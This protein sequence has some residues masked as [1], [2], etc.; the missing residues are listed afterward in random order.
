MVGATD[1]FTNVTNSITTNVLII[2]DY[3]TGKG[4]N[5]TQFA[6]GTIS[7]Y[8]GSGL[9]YNSSN[10]II[11]T[12]SGGS[13]AYYFNTTI[14]NVTGYNSMLLVPYNPKTARVSST[15][16]SGNT[17]IANYITPKTGL[18]FIPFGSYECHDHVAETTGNK[19]VQIYCIIT[20]VAANG[21][22][23]NTIGT[24]ELSPPLTSSETE[25]RIYY[26][27]ANTYTIN[28]S[29]R[30][31][32][33]IYASV[34][35]GGSSP[36]VTQWLGGEADSHFAMPAS[37][38]SSGGGA[39][40]TA[41]TLSGLYL[42]SNNEFGIAVDQNTI[43]AS[44]ILFNGANEL[45]A[46]S[47]GSASNSPPIFLNTLVPNNIGGVDILEYMLA[48]F[49][50]LLFVV[51]LLKYK[52]TSAWWI[53]AETVSGICMMLALA[54]FILIPSNA[55]VTTTTGNV[56][57]TAVN[58]ISNSVSNSGLILQSWEPTALYLFIAVFELC[59]VVFLFQDIPIIFFPPKLP[60]S[61][62]Y[63][64]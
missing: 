40:Y 54:S 64:R 31:E 23:I 51:R 1:A 55:V 36:Q 32:V 59:I 19:N 10:A 47:S 63:D 41:N 16:S 58:I 28:P 25:F 14:S 13:T 29:S 11:N 18:S 50:I 24:T 60:K 7:T 4:I 39:T 46:I 27:T 9:G 6:N 44:D 57:S 22:T 34:S 37:S 52:E 53:V 21:M 45:S 61:P 5:L 49:A 48:G 26:V 43:V 12:G 8:V 33:S 38:G 15:L 17:I 42:T 20:E 35:G 3:T 2:P 30:I 62:K 56:G